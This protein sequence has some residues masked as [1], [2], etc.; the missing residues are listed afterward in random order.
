MS[1]RSFIALRYNLKLQVIWIPVS[2]KMGV[3]VPFIQGSTTSVHPEHTA[4]RTVDD[5][6]RQCPAEG[7][8]SPERDGIYRQP[9]SSFPYD[10]KGPPLWAESPTQAQN[11]HL[12]QKTPLS[13][14]ALGQGTLLSQWSEVSPVPVAEVLCAPQTQ[15]KQ[16][17]FFILSL[18]SCRKS[19]EH[20]AAQV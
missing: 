4:I 10:R 13:R 20:W 7:R 1:V 5:T 9:N 19:R 6:P 2:R 15:S 11:R 3:F 16:V 12:Q 14:L 17:K 8:P 18:P